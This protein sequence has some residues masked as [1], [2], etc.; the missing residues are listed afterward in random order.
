MRQ[1]AVADFNATVEAVQKPFKTVARYLPKS[2]Q[3]SKPAFR[4]VVRQE[5]PLIASSVE[6]ELVSV[7]APGNGKSSTAAVQKAEA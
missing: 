7:E 2:S 3:P 5:Q 6:E 4:P 1:D